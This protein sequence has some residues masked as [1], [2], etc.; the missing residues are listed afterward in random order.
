MKFLKHFIVA[1]IFVLLFNHSLHYLYGSYYAQVPFIVA[2][3]ALCKEEDRPKLVAH[4]T[5]YLMVMYQCGKRYGEKPEYIPAASLD[6]FCKKEHTVQVY[7]DAK[8]SCVE[9]FFPKGR[10]KFW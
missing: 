2:E 7:R 8:L 6:G 9:G 1:G 4:G 3:K 5:N 10:W